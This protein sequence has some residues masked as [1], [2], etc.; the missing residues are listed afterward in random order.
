MNSIFP[1]VEPC[2]LCGPGP[3]AYPSGK[4]FWQAECPRCGLLGPEA[5]G[6]DEARQLWNEFALRY[7]PL[8]GEAHRLAESC[9]DLVAKMPPDLADLYRCCQHYLHSAAENLRM[10]KL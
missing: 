5:I 6:F 3:R 10:R 9:A 4:E 2:P 8:A 1:R 7:H